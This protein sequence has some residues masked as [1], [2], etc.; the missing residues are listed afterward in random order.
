MRKSVIALAVAAML[1]L[2]SIASAAVFNFNF[3]PSTSLFGA[4]VSGSGTFTTLDTSSQVGGQTAFEIVSIQGT[5]NGS[6]ITAPTSAAGY[7]NY[8]TTGPSFLDGT[9]VTFSDAAGTTLRFLT[10]AA[11]ASIASIHSARVF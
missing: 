10:K 2:P 3:A 9:G 6:A 5:V 11:M 8:F 7:G 1:G 4:P